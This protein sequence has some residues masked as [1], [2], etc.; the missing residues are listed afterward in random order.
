LKYGKSNER[1][2]ED[3]KE[4]AQKTSNN[5]IVRMLEEFQITTHIERKKQ[6][7]I[8][9]INSKNYDTNGNLNLVRGYFEKAFGNQIIIENNES[10]LS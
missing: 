2:L 10:R 1:I 8:M 4:E 5:T 3:A 9:S 7:R 6:R